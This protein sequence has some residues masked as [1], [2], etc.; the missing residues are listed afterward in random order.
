LYNVLQT[1]SLDVEKACRIAFDI[2]SGLEYAHNRHIIHGD[3]NPKNVLLTSS[4][5]AKITDFGLAKIVSSST[6]V[7]G[8]T[9]L[10][11]PVEVLEKLIA[12]EKSD[13]YQLGLT[14]YVM[15]T[16]CNPF[17]AD[18][19]Y[20]IEEKIKNLTPE[21]PSKY[22]PVFSDLDDLIMRCLSKKPADRPS[23]REFRESIYEFIKKR[24]NVSLPL[25]EDIDKIL[26]ITC[27][28]ALMAAK[29]GDIGECLR[30]LNSAKEKIRDPEIRNEMKKLIENVE[31]RAKNEI[32]LEQL[33]DK[34]EIFLKKVQWK[35]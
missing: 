23:L 18:S 17:E 30:A 2:A 13:V 7:K 4:G 3:I 6:Q 31:Y 29:Q 27:N 10:Y 28:Y 21:P 22:N 33:L 12:D 35:G 20:E 19:K 32:T 24:Y 9:L 1:K 15:L 26:A 14:T 16:G 5:E 11:A 8:Y 34:M 25:T